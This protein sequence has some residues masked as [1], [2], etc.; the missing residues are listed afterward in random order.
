M[1]WPLCRIFGNCKDGGLF[2]VFGVIYNGYF[3]CVFLLLGGFGRDYVRG[4]RPGV[5]A[6]CGEE[7]AKREEG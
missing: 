1:F 4:G 7:E 2:E 6:D 3:L 5:F